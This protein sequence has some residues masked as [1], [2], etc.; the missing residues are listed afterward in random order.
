M[1]SSGF[2]QEDTVFLW[3]VVAVAWLLWLGVPATAVHYRF[4]RAALG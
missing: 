2:G 3:S 1:R 4:R